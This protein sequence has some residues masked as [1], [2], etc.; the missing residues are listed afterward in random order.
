MRIMEADCVQGAAAG[1]AGSQFI[2]GVISPWAKVLPVFGAIYFKGFVSTDTVKVG[3]LAFDILSGNQLVTMPAVL[4][5]FIGVTAISADMPIGIGTGSGAIAV[6]FDFQDII[7]DGLFNATGI[8]L[9]ATFGGT[10][11]AGAIPIAAQVTSM[12]AYIDNK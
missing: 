7:G 4:D 5:K 1:D 2:L 12:I 6:P 10:N 8:V 3:Y 9:A 11:A